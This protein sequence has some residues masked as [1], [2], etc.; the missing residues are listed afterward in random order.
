MT[1][2]EQVI[3]KTREDLEK[4]IRDYTNNPTYSLDSQ[5]KS[6]ILRFRSQKYVLSKAKI[7]FS[8]AHERAGIPTD[9]PNG[10]EVILTDDW[11]KDLNHFLVY[12]D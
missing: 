7:F 5:P 11:I 1:T 12:Q 8:L 4:A 6:G 3:D 10:N 2:V 9:A